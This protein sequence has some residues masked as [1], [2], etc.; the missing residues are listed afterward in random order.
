MLGMNEDYAVVLGNLGNPRDRFLA[1]GY[2]DMASDDG[3]WEHL[4]R[5]D[6]VRGVELVGT[7][8]IDE[9][10]VEIVRRRLQDLALSCVSIIPD[11]FSRRQWGRGSYSAPSKET[12]NQAVSYTKSMIDVAAEL[13]CSLLNIWPGQDGYDYPLAADYLEE[14]SWFVESLRTCSQY[15]AGKSIKVALEYK[16]KEPRTHSYLARAADT[17]LTADQIGLDNVGVTIDTGHAFVAYENV[18]E[19][20]ALLSLAGDRLYHIHFNDNLGA[21]DDDMIAGSFRLVEYFEMLYWLRE[22]GYRGWYSMDQYPYREDAVG[23][24]QSSIDFLRQIGTVLDSVGQD[25]VR[26]L[27][28]QRDPVQTSA[29]IREHLLQGT[30]PA[31]APTGSR[32]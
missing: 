21:W 1:E 26:H 11:T 30:P 2:K 18:G 27:I 22:T 9:S 16:V 28:R 25:A 20:I 4:A 6:G 32:P 8:D 5:L 10:N 12:R 7:W 14:R 29:F 19:V 3:L 24:V 23:A 13:G 17:L 15:A 31:G